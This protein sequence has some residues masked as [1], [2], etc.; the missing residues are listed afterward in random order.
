MADLKISQLAALASADL[1]AGDLLPVVDLSASETKKITVT[2]FT[3]KAVTLIADASIPGA[4]ILFGTQQ[5]PGTALIDSGV[6]N[7]KIADDAVTAA[8]LANES[9]VDLVTT[10]PATGA[11]TGQLALDTDDLKVYCWN[12]SSWQSIKAAGS[13]NTI[14]GST[15]GVVNVTVTTS[16]DTV[17]IATTL[18]NTAAASQFL[19]GPTA[20]AGAVSYRTI[21]AGDL[22]TA[23]TTA[24][25]AVQVNGNGLSMTGDTIQ[26]A[27]TVTANAAAYH[28]VQ[29]TSKGL[30]SAGRT[31][32]SGDLPL[33]GA[34]AVG[35]VYPGSGLSVAVDGQ[36]NHSNTVTPGTSAKVTYNAQGHVTAGSSLVAADIPSLD[37]SKIT[38]GVLISDVIGSKTVTS[39]KLADYSTVKFGGA[40]STTGIVTF[41]VP[42][43]TGQLFFD[44]SNGDLYLYD[45]NTWQPVTVISGDLIYAGTYNAANNTVKSVTTAGSAAGLVV[46]SALPAGSAARNRYYVVVSDAGNGVSPAPATALAPPDMLV[47][48]GATWDLVDVSNAIAGQIASNISFTPYAGLAST[49]VQTVI[50]ELEDEKLA[51]A[52]GIV[53][54]ALEI[55]TTGSLVFEGSTDDGFETT[56]AVANPTADRTITLPNVTGTVVTTGDTGTVTSTMIADGTIVNADI[57]A[58]AAI[59]DTKLAT[60]S[61]AGKVANSATTATNANTPSAIVARDPSGNFS[62]GTIT[63]ALAGNAS[64]ATAL[65]TGQTISLTGDVTGTSTAF[66]GSAPLSFAAT[67]ANSGVSAS[68]Y[69]GNNSIPSLTVDAKG[70]ITSA[71][72]VVPSGTWAINVSGTAG[73]VTNLAGGSLGTIPYQSAANTTAMLGV[74]TSGQALVSA[75]AAAPTWSTLTL[76]N[77]PDA[78]FKKSVRVA[79]TAD[80]GASTFSAGVL[81]GYDDTFSLNVTT[82]LGSTTATT[83]STAGIKQGATIS[84][85][86]NIPGGATVA[87]ITNATTFV[88]SAAATAA[89][90]AVATTFTQTIAALSVDGVT[91]ALNDRILVK[92]QTSTLQNGIY[93]LSTLGSTTVPWVLTRANDADS[94]SEIGGAIVNVDSGTT[95]GARLFTA[96]FKTTDTLNTSAMVWSEIIDTSSANSTAGTIAMNGTQ[97][98]GTSNLY[99]RADHVHPVDTSRAAVGQT[100]FIGTTST[101]INR[102]SANQA[103]TGISSVAMP[104]AT[105]GTV[106]V[107]PAA[108]AGTTAITLPATTGTLITTGDTGTVTNTM[109]AGSIAITKLVSSTISGVSL[110]SNLNSLTLGAGLTGTSYNGSAAVTAAVSYGTTAGTACQGNDSRLSDAR[111]NPNA[112]TFNNSGAGAASGTTY[113]GSAAVTVSYNTIGAAGT[114]ANNTFTAAQRASIG[115]LTDGATITPDF[116]TANNF[117]VT[118]AGNRTLAA[119]TNQ[120]AGQSGSI[121]IV[122][123]ATGSRT[124]A[125]AADWDF[126]GGTAP[127]LSTAANAVDRLDYIVRA[128]GDIH[129]ILTK[130]YS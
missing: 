118:L 4:K 60:I 15:S 53:T 76:E 35:A 72:T 128:S 64:T 126:A 81:T 103:L 36:L 21:A 105:S 56:V 68:T 48:N 86:A 19:A 11:F 67:L 77:L 129:A 7:A 39:A 23:S 90:T 66:N 5:V 29:Y 94:A 43:F 44:S 117:T 130:A 70:R 13:I 110:G 111:V 41:P 102:A 59:V 120:V 125:Y 32:Q 62:A 14:N 87:L 6:S 30:V 116:A 84:G 12:G 89:G 82:T 97:A 98:A 27:N 2:D 34:S 119:P 100:M 71:T 46:G 51:K 9:T 24:K 101:A 115:T 109:L 17:T 93:R 65:A 58:S 33:A 20:A 52:G 50:Q 88:L 122:Q 80:V 26:I 112:V 104:G 121:F 49:N 25:G 73:L 28:V 96:A 95:N 61:T 91:L 83:T 99:A 78:A 106:T 92:D 114:A 69:G 8:K 57:N 47:C 18:D 42:E 127:T 54:G 40:S 55:G 74:G 37:A 45:G 63:A 123:D 1:A 85:N 75:G 16:G 3:G 38:S 108:V 22:P 113:T 31:I 124:L 79:T 10:L 107:T